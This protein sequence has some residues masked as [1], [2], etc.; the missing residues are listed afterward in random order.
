[1]AKP[2]FLTS[3]KNPFLKDVRRAAL[4]GTLTSDGYCIA[5]TFHLLEEALRSDLEVQAVLSAESVRSAVETHVR[6][7]RKTKVT[8]VPDDVFMD[9]SATDSAQ[10]VMALVKPPVWTLDHLFRGMSM[11]V[12]LDGLQDPGNA[13]AILR[14]AEGFGATGVMFL[15][16]TVS[17]W[18]PK[19]IRASAGSIF[20]LPQ[21]SDVDPSLA[22]VAFRQR[23]VDVYALTAHGGKALPDANLTR[24]CALVI[25]NEGR[26]VSETLREGATGLHIRTCRVESLNASVAAA[27]VLYEAHRQRVRS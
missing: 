17:A 24:R 25:G 5:E 15:K 9:L 18:N 1:M 3:A 20:R 21:V 22:R 10:G 11:V 7:L 6:G 19:T 2:E 16:G 13:G 8:I 27:V 23:Q 4:K 26:G 14:T 12:V